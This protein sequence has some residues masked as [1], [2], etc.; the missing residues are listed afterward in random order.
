M[1]AIR[2]VSNII[3]NIPVPRAPYRKFVRASQQCLRRSQHVFT[4]VPSITISLKKGPCT[5]KGF[6]T[7]LECHNCRLTVPDRGSVLKELSICSAAYCY[8]HLKKL[9]HP[10]R[11]DKF[12]LL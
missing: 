8:K 12:L 1:E 2:E 7:Q 9:L 4:S 10:K 6:K 5:Q 3:T 11:K